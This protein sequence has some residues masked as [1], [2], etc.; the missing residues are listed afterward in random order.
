M[1]QL[2][3][4]VLPL[5][6]LVEVFDNGTALVGGILRARGKQVDR[7]V[8]TNSEPFVHADHDRFWVQPLISGK[9]CQYSRVTLTK[10]ATVLTT[11][12]ASPLVSG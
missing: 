12:S 6:A 5:V 3:G 8:L 7:F 4:A 10:L 2:V 1:I 9:W 11:L